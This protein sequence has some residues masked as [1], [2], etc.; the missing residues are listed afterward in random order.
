MRRHLIL[1][2]L[3]AFAILAIM[4]FL[5]FWLLRGPVTPVDNTGQLGEGGPRTAIA[6]EGNNVGGNIETP[7]GGGVAQNNT[8]VGT[9]IQTPI[10]PGYGSIPTNTRPSGG[11]A[12][13]PYRPGGVWVDGS[14]VSTTSVSGSGS[15]RTFTPTPIN[16]LTDVD[17]AG[18]GYFPTTPNESAGSGGGGGGLFGIGVAV[19]GCA[20]STLGGIAGGSAGNAGAGVGAAAGAAAVPTID[21]GTHAILTAQ[22]TVSNTIESSE[23]YK[24]NFLDCIARTIARAAIE[25][26]TADVVDWINSGFEGKPAFVQDFRGFFR[27]IADDAAGEFISG[28]KLAFLCSPFQLQVKIAVSKSYAQRSS[29]GSSNACTLSDVT[30]NIRSFIE[31]NFSQGGWPAFLEF[32]TVP[33][34]NPFGAFM[35]VEAQ[36]GNE[37]ANIQAEARLELDLGQGFLLF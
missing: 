3:G 33:T 12:Y 13:V 2:F 5:W 21:I 9:N 7:I 34:N 36:L 26:I 19:V 18:T 15:P 25:R 30:N 35:T 1:I 8:G 4:F 11:I 23:A 27:D 10:Q 16:Q 22:L 24:E 31:G 32:T 37:I 28:S 14:Y 6:G 29:G 17:I 20:A